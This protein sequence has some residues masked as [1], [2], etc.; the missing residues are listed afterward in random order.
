MKIMR[1]SDWRPRLLDYL[2]TVSKQPFEPGVNDCA[3]FAAGGLAA[4]T[5]VDLSAEWRGQYTT[6]EQGYALLRAAGHRDHIA[7]A[8][9]HLKEIPAAFAGVGDVAV[10][11]GSIGD[12]LGIVQGEGIYVLT[13][14]G[15]GVVPLDHAHQAFRVA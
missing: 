9:Q 14:R 3:L 8:A 12:S 15:L 6:L 4:M 2:L 10:V 11:A 1:L 5:G 7:L 13:L